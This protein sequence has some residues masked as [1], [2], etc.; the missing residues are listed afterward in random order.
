MLKGY[1]NNDKVVNVIE[2]LSNARGGDI[3]VDTTDNE[4]TCRATLNLTGDVPR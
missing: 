2:V 3:G 4:I 1:I